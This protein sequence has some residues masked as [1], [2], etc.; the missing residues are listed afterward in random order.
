MAQFTFQIPELGNTPITVEGETEEAALA[1]LNQ[2]SEQEIRQAARQSLEARASRTDLSPEDIDAILGEGGHKA[3]GTGALNTLA[4][5][6]GRTM[7]NRARGMLQLARSALPTEVADNIGIPSTATMQ[8]DE[9]QARELFAQID[10]GVGLEDVGEAI[11]EMVAFFGLGAAG[12]GLKAITA[13]S[14][15]GATSGLLAATG[16]AGGTERAFN[17][18]AGAV[19][20]ALAPLLGASAAQVGRWVKSVPGAL[21][22][23]MAVLAAAKGNAPTAV[24]AATRASTRAAAVRNSA[25]HA[26]QAARAAGESTK[27]A[28]TVR[29]LADQA[30][31]RLGTLIGQMRGRHAENAAFQAA[32]DAFEE[33]FDAAT[34]A[35][36]PQAVVNRLAR[37]T[38]ADLRRMGA[39]GRRLQDYRAWAKD[40]IDVDDA[41]PQ[42]VQQALTGMF[43]SERARELARAMGRAQNPEAKRQLLGTMARIGGA[44]AGGQTASTGPQATQAIF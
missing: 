35:F 15:I 44:I 40:L 5:G 10:E 30:Q 8:A 11:P 16:E 19:S 21:N 6:A 7:T 41:D 18:T 3:G 26:V 28:A 12:L 27:N 36:N 20:G 33:G 37:F 42:Q 17:T 29:V 31:D 39:A 4:I 23:G 43:E 32:N 13:G 24:F 1:A 38:P 9:E 2:A 25:E 22:T 14:T 34:G